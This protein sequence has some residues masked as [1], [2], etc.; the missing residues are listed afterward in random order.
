MDQAGR[1]IHSLQR[2]ICS[3]SGL[4][5]TSLEDQFSY[6]QSW[7]QGGASA[8]QAQESVVAPAGLRPVLWWP[9][10]SLTGP[11]WVCLQQIPFN[12][13]IIVWPSNL[14]I[15]RLPSTLLLILWSFLSAL[16]KVECLQ[17]KHT[18]GRIYRVTESLGAGGRGLMITTASPAY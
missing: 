4:G 5:K 18:P 6:R 11:R 14:M 7:P 13:G 12:I 8:L 3:Q 1:W 16:E 9:R 2:I 15:P 17:Q 10:D